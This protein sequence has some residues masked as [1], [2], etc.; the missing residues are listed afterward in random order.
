M[1]SKAVE[2]GIQTPE[3]SLSLTWSSGL[4]AAET[5]PEKLTFK[6][7][8]VAIQEILGDPCEVP[9]VMLFT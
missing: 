6:L 8:D 7:I 5:L 4:L 1:T 2:I 9:V 3:V